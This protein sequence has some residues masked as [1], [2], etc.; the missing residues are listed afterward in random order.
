MLTSKVDICAF[1]WVD[2]PPLNLRKKLNGEHAKKRASLWIYA[3][4]I[5]PLNK[6]SKEYQS[7][8]QYDL[9]ETRLIKDSN[10][11]LNNEI[12]MYWPG[13]ISIIMFSWDEM[14]GIIVH[15]NKSYQSLKSIFNFTWKNV[16]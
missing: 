15:S 10:F 3:K 9:R 6:N 12:D 8:D 7:S 1:V 5:S 14:T 2:G 4:V 11:Q 16:R 13:K